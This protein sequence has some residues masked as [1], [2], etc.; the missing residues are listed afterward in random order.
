MAFIVQLHCNR[1][2]NNGGIECSSA[3][4][5]HMHDKD[6]MLKFDVISELNNIRKNVKIEIDPFAWS[7]EYYRS[8]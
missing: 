8:H 6:D 7:N 3:V 4:E 2:Y 5:W 1:K